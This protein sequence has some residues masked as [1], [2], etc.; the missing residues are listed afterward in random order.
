MTR[1]MGRAINWSGRNDKGRRGAESYCSISG[2][3]PK[4]AVS[5]NDSVF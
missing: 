2:G 4:T 5:R 3:I 1:Q